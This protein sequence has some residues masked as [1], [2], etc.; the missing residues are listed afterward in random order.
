[1]D[2]DV[3]ILPAFHVNDKVSVASLTVAV[4]AGA[5]PS[6][7]ILF[8]DLVPKVTVISEIVPAGWYVVVPDAATLTV[9]LQML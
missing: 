4:H 6:E 3:G 8:T 9:D 7:F 5:T 1:M 2:V